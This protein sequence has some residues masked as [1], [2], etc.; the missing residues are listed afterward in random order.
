MSFINCTSI[1]SSF[2]LALT[3]CVL[4]ICVIL[5]SCKALEVEQVCST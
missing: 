2:F 3:L 5:L 1:E 4:Y